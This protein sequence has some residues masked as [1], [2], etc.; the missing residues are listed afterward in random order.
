V[1][2]RRM[3]ITRDCL[4]R[5]WRIDPGTPLFQLREVF[6][7]PCDFLIVLH[8]SKDTF[9]EIYKRFRL[10]EWHA[11]IHLAIFKVAR[12]AMR[13]QDR[14]NV[15]IEDQILNVSHCSLCT[16]MSYFSSMW[17]ASIREEKYDERRLHYRFNELSSMPDN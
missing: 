17:C 13:L 11:L 6:P 4:I 15:F 3:A 10:I 12:F 16:H 14:L 7:D 1:I 8:P 5:N 9:L 2:P